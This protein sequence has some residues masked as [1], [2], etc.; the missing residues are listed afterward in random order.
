MRT[1]PI[2]SISNKRRC[3]MQIAPNERFDRPVHAT[4]ANSATATTGS[5]RAREYPARNG[6]CGGCPATTLAFPASALQPT[7]NG[8]RSMAM[9]VDYRGLVAAVG[10]ASLGLCGWGLLLYTLGERLHCPSMI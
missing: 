5:D 1:V 7:R 6:M 2:A 3:S 4:A 8:S 9:N 10:A